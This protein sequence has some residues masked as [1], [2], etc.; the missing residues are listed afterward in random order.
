MPPSRP[1]IL[2]GAP[3]RRARPAAFLR[4]LRRCHA[5]VGLA[6]LGFGLLFGGTG[7][8]MNHRAIMRIDTG[9]FQERRVTVDLPE[10]PATPEALARLLAAR[11]GLAPERV[12]WLVKPARA[13]RLGD[14]EVTAPEQWN[15]LFIGHAH[16]ARANYVPGNRSLDV[17]QKDANLI[18]ALERLHKADAGQAGLILVMDAFA[19]ALV[20]LSLSGA[21]LWT[22]FDG[23]RLLAAG[24]ASGTVVAALLVASRCW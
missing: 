5:W 18:G 22:R 23:P 6:G 2:N 4:T 16:F 3:E 24:L 12:K 19:G 7:F 14:A 11:F 10:A 21:L 17:E 1:E 20:F 8:L 9:A 13:G 15:L